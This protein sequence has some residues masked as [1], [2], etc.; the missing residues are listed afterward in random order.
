MD[1]SLREISAKDITA[2]VKRLCMEAN[3][4]LPEDIKE[5]IN[6]CEQAEPWDLA[7]NI[8]GIIHENYLIAEKAYGKTYGASEIRRVIR[9]EVEDQIA[10]CIIHNANTLR[11]LTITAKDGKLVVQ[12]EEVTAWPQKQNKRKTAEQKLI[13][14]A[15]F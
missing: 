5:K 8:L 11:A 15:V 3:S 13:C 1:Y 14:S 7:K 6:A 2:Q 4:Y 10:E 9:Q 12:D